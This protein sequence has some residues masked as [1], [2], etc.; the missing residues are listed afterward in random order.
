MLRRVCLSCERKSAWGRVISIS[1]TDPDRDDLKYAFNAN[2][3]MKNWGIRDD[4]YYALVKFVVISASGLPPT[5]NNLSLRWLMWFGILGLRRKILHLKRNSLSSTFA[6]QLLFDLRLD[7]KVIMSFSISFIPLS[8][9]GNLVVLLLQLTNGCQHGRA[10]LGFQLHSPFLEKS[11]AT[12]SPKLR[13]RVIY[14]RVRRGEE[15][16]GEERSE[17]RY[18]GMPK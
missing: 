11:Q 14:G 12:C 1:A 5:K 7:V 4:H 18:N 15:R 16:R 10:E 3:F 8:S 9:D 13:R 17:V 6:Y 2:E